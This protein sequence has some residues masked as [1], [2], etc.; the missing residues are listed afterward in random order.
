VTNGDHV[1][2]NILYNGVAG[3]SNSISYHAQT[4]GIFALGTTPIF[5]TAGQTITVTLVKTSTD[6]VTMNS[7]NLYAVFVPRQSNPH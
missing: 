3:P 6:V 4:F 1:D 5:I 2:I 7:Q